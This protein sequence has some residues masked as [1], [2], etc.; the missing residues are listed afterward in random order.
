MDAETWMT[1]EHA[2]AE[3]LADEVLEPPVAAKAS[4]A[5]QITAL[6]ESAVIDDVERLVAEH[7]E[8]TGAKREGLVALRARIDGLLTE[9]TKSDPDDELRRQKAAQRAA[10]FRASLP[11]AF[12]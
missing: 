4:L 3:G 12:V 10:E 2:V 9:E 11:A 7:G 6:T 8:L 1:A 5:D